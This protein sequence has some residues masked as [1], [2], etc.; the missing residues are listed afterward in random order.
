[1]PPSPDNSRPICADDGMPKQQICK[2]TW[3][4]LPISL[5]TG[6]L[7]YLNPWLRLALIIG[8]VEYHVRQ[9]HFQKVVAVTALN[10]LAA[11]LLIALLWILA[12]RVRNR[13]PGEAARRFLLIL[14]V[15]SLMRSVA[16]FVPATGNLAIAFVNLW[17]VVAALAAS[18][19]FSIRAGWL[20]K[21][22]RAVSRAS[23]PLSILS[24]AMCM[25]MIIPVILAFGVDKSVSE[26]SVHAQPSVTKKKEAG[27]DG[28]HPPRIVWVIFDEFD[29]SLA[30][31]NRPEGMSLPHI[32]RFA[33]ESVNFSRASSTS[34]YTVT[35]VPSLLTGIP[36][37]R[38]VRKKTSDVILATAEAD[39]EYSFRKT[40][41]VISWANEAGVPVSLIGWTHP[42]CRVFGDRL[43][44][45]AWYE[46]NHMSSAQTWAVSLRNLE[47]GEALYA[48]AHQE[49]LGARTDP[50]NPTSG[51]DPAKV[52]LR[53]YRA[54]ILSILDEQ[55]VEAAKFLRSGVGGLSILHLATPH[56]PG[57]VARTAPPGSAS[58]EL[59]MV[60]NYAVADSIFGEIRSILEER[61]EWDSALVILT[62][63]HGL[64]SFWGDWGCLTRVEQ[65]ML[66]DRNELR[67]PLMIKL[68]G[69][70]EHGVI[71]RKVE[72]TILAPLV[73]G[74]LER[75][76]LSREEL[77]NYLEG[78]ALHAS[79]SSP[80]ERNT[81]Q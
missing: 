69:T 54:S 49:A 59:S 56:P 38:V 26:A 2:I 77:A 42:Y 18:A 40:P 67:V 73:R 1:M 19:L 24:V 48:Q 10:T 6:A 75:G 15:L 39:T 52:G 16:L 61:G 60:E 53:D 78:H 50:C 51:A 63:D 57:A 62:S 64:R 68:P 33:R 34:A 13:V 43:A 44:Q 8:D 35:A 76:A 47:F 58:A 41:S 22:E 4:I 12:I 55:R 74:V 70:G 81:L 7:L 25:A 9:V 65:A 46:N 5:A 17:L 14:F 21:A 23:R 28:S 20:A 72:T 45:C 29:A 11:T 32:D 79:N 3:H 66:H 71:E 27:A 31:D 30:F 36:F 80:F 37:T